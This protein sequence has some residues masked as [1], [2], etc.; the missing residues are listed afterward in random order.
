MSATIVAYML[1][2]YSNFIL[3]MYSDFSVET[4]LKLQT[5]YDIGQRICSSYNIFLS[6]RL[7]NLQYP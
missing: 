4:V 7:F 3:N 6:S 1:N 2:M 5:N